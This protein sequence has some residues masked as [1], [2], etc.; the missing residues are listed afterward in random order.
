[1]SPCSHV[2]AHPAKKGLIFLLP[3]KLTI[4]PLKTSPDPIT[5]NSEDE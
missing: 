1:M 4:K 2:D 3:T 5:A